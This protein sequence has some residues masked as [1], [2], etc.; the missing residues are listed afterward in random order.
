VKVTEEAGLTSFARLG[1]PVWRD[2]RLRH[3]KY[4]EAEWRDLRACGL[5]APSI[6]LST[7]PV[8]TSAAI[9]P[10]TASSS[11]APAASSSSSATVSNTVEVLYSWLGQT[12]F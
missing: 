11:S 2:T 8:S 4:L 10:Q 1:C 9:A 12:C 7:T 5:V 6:P 3:A